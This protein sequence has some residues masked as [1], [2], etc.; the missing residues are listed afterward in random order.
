MSRSENAAAR[1]LV[2]SRDAVWHYLDA[3]LQDIPEESGPAVVEQSPPADTRRVKAEPQPVA[4]VAPLRSLFRE[5]PRADPLA[6]PVE[7]GPPL[8]SG[9]APALESGAAPQAEPLPEWRER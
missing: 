1:E 7:S 8:A 9:G 6:V 2:D 3:L 5:E 4:E